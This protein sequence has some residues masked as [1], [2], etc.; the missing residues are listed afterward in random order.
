[1]SAFSEEALLAELLKLHNQDRWGGPL[2]IADGPLRR[3]LRK[4]GWIESYL[5]RNIRRAHFRISAAGRE[6]LVNVPGSG[7]T[8]DEPL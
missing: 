5:P 1:M 3:A 4:Q 7:I 8:R 6:R 2:A